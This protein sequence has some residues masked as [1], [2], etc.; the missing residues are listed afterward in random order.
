MSKLKGFAGILTAKG[1]DAAYIEQVVKS[2]GSSLKRGSIQEI[3]DT[4]LQKESAIAGIVVNLSV[5]TDVNRGIKAMTPDQM[6]VEMRKVLTLKSEI[7]ALK[8]ERKEVV[9]PFFSEYFPDKN[10]S[11]D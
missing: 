2:V 8:R 3:D 1:V 4:I 9:E 7:N 5:E 10:A 11:D 6:V